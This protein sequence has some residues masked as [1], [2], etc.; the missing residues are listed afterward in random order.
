MM[1]NLLQHLLHDIKVPDFLRRRTCR[2][3]ELVH[4]ERGIQAL[5]RWILAPARILDRTCFSD[6][7]S[8]LE[9]VLALELGLLGAHGGCIFLNSSTRGKIEFLVWI[10]PLG[11]DRSH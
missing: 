7:E 1:I 10:V 9:P 2:S 8:A 5:H 6:T 4:D 11:I 3:N